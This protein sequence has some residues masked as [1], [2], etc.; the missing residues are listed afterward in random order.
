MNEKLKDLPQTQKILFDLKEYIATNNAKIT[1]DLVGEW[2][3]V[4]GDDTKQY[5]D[6]IKSLGFHWSKNKLKWY[7]HEKEFKKF[8][9]KQ[10]TYE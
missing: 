3:W 9:K 5:K 1:I 2:L 7:Y 8:N 6:Y 10:Y 4:Y